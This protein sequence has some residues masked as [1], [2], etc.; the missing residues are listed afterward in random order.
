[1]AAGRFAK[2]LATTTQ[3]VS[4][5]DPVAARATGRHVPPGPA[6]RLLLHGVRLKRVARLSPEAEEVLLTYH[7]P[8]WRARAGK[9]PSSG[10]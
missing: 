7:W 4:A 5:G 10:R 1:M 2:D 9:T 8:N 6:F 3:R